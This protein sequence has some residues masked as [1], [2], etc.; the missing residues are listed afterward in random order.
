MSN[1]AGLGEPFNI[2]QYALLL[3]MVA[4]VTNHDVKELIMV[5]GDHHIY[6]NHYDALKEMVE[7]REPLPLCKLVL[8]PEVEDIFDFTG[9]DIQIE[10]YQRHPSIKLPV[11]I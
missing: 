6:S 8:N 5:R 4:H 10:D 7:T 11:A 9:E 1:D 3:S 2:A